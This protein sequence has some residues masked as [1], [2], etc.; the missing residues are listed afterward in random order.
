MGLILSLA[1]LGGWASVARAAESQLV[2]I[3]ATA[4]R[5]DVAR[6]LQLEAETI[7]RLKALIAQQKAQAEGLVISG[8]DAKGADAQVNLEAFAGDSQRHGLELLSRVQQQ[9]LHQILICDQG[10]QSLRDAAVAKSLELTPVQRTQI[11]QQWQALEETIARRGPGA[12]SSAERTFERNASLLLSEEQ[13]TAWEQLAGLADEPAVSAVPRGESADV[14]TASNNTIELTAIIDD[15]PLEKDGEGDD[16]EEDRGEEV[17][18]E[19]RGEQPISDEELDGLISDFEAADADSSTSEA[20]EMDGPEMEERVEA[21]Q[22]SPETESLE[23]GADEVEAAPAPA[24]RDVREEE[25]PQVERPMGDPRGGDSRGFDSRGRDFRGGPTEGGRP[26]MGPSGRFGPGGERGT[27][28]RDYSRDSSPRNAAPRDTIPRDTTTNDAAPRGFGEDRPGPTMDRTPQPATDTRPEVDPRAAAET[29]GAAESASDREPKDWDEVK[30]KFNF[31]YHPW[32]DV[33]DW[34]A[35]QADL[36]LVMDAPPSGTFNYIDGKL[37]NPTEALDV[38]NSVLLTKGYTLVRRGQMLMVVNLEDGI[39]P[40]WVE[41]VPLENLD[42]RA[43]YE[44]ISVM[45]DLRRMTPEEASGEVKQLMGPQGSI[46]TLSKSQQLLITETAGR[47]RT[48]RDVIDAVENPNGGNLTSYRLEHLSAME[49]LP[50]IRSLLGMAEEENVTPDGSLR[51]ASDT[52]GMRLFVTGKK[53]AIQEFEDILKKVDTL[54][55]DA[56]GKPPEQMQIEVYSLGT[57]DPTTALQVVQT[58]LSGSPNVRLSVDENTASLIALCRP[59]EHA[60]IRATLDQMRR[61]SKQTAVVHLQVVDPQVAVMSINKLYGAVGETPAPNAPVIDADPVSRQLFVRGTAQQVSEIK[62]VLKQMGEDPEA[63]REGRAGRGNIRNLNLKGNSAERVLR[64]L[65]TLWPTVSDNNRIR[66]VRPGSTTD[67]GR[68]NLREWKAPEGRPAPVSSPAQDSTTGRSRPD[69]DSEAGA[70]FSDSP[71]R[72]VSET[73]T[74][75]VEDWTSDVYGKPTPPKALAAEGGQIE[76]IHEVSD[77]ESLDRQDNLDSRQV[78][79]QNSA[80]ASQAI[81]PGNSSGIGVQRGEIVIMAGPNGLVLASD[82]IEALNQV[83]DLIELLS[84]RHATSGAQ[85]SVYYLKHARADVA[86]SLLQG[87]MTGSS[88]TSDEEGSL[89][90]DLASDM[91]GG[92]SMMGSLMGLGGMGGGT[93]GATTLSMGTMS[94][95]AD[96]RLNALVIQAHPDDLEKIDQLLNVIDQPYSPEPVETK[97]KPRLIPVNFTSAQNVATVV[98]QVYADQIATPQ[99]QG[100]QRQPSPEDFIRALRGGGRGGR[101]GGGEGGGAQ[102]EPEKMTIGVD[103]RSN[104]LV[105]SAPDPL[106]ESVKSLVEQLDQAGDDTNQSMKVIQIKNSTPAVIQKA[107]TSLTGGAVTTGSAP[108]NTPGTQAAGGGAP[109]AADADAIRQR[110]EAFGRMRGMM[111]QGGGGFRGGDR[112]DRGGRGGDTGGRGGRRGDSGG[113]GG[114]GGR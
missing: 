88:T 49:A 20:V 38:L 87:I 4:V 50:I 69:L 90:G 9:R 61:D 104:S 8:G 42:E 99:G 48:I 13:M 70:T 103:T 63:I 30:I 73:V 86:A 58:L 43:E 75:A 68:V 84:E 85:F 76:E 32:R 37:Y 35:E 14:N 26:S 96:P 100:Q 95:I 28:G 3:L 25:S 40:T 16:D 29:P 21:A 31:R 71:F 91:L 101:G 93:G 33:L 94:V 34:F 112:G 113:R 62:E 36:S 81:P 19:E 15:E 1:I 107:L 102:S 98:Q 64:D 18:G 60:T 10:M 56:V 12:R 97:A 111:E 5:P 24:E 110:M 92:G 52:L 53:D 80:E 79:S 57:A 6:E 108:T 74:P 22:S 66:I 89:L 47:L 23:T 46:T 44:L 72:Y 2:G 17:N 51:I 39:P 65:E 27:S 41:K 109:S 7:E 77:W 55:T 82:D 59:S 11:E 67:T 106:F 54:D 78:T 105:V 45:F 83:E 114:R